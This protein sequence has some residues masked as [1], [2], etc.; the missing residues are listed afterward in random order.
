MGLGQLPAITARLIEGGMAPD[1]PAAVIE[2]GTLPDQR[3]VRAPLSGI[4]AKVMEAGIGTPAIIVVGETASFDMK[5]D[6]KC[7]SFGPLAGYRIGMVAHG[8]LQTVLDM[9]LNRRERL[10]YQS[11]R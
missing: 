7:R 1:T 8:I 5:C 2:N 11:W 6:L 3:A 10:S 9:P 4:H